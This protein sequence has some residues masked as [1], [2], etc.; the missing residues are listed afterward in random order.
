MVTLGIFIYQQVTTNGERSVSYQRLVGF[1]LQHGGY[2]ERARGTKSTGDC[3]GRVNSPLHT[4]SVPSFKYLPKERCAHHNHIQR[5]QYQ[6]QRFVFLLLE[7]RDPLL[8]VLL[9]RT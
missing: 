7:A 1:V 3:A 4:V 2:L 5:K 8:R 9:S 6:V